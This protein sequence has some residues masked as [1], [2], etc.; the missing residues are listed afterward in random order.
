MLIY[1]F[2]VVLLLLLSVMLLS[3]TNEIDELNPRGGPHTLCIS[4]A[5][6][7]KNSKA[8]PMW[9]L[10]VL[11]CCFQH[12]QSRRQVKLAVIVMLFPARSLINIYTYIPKNFPYDF[13]SIFVSLFLTLDVFAWLGCKGFI[14]R[15]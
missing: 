1:L 15:I 13:C 7:I 11:F 9:W 4:N 6:K 2:L 14:Q 12:I 5:D 8:F 10:A 3:Y